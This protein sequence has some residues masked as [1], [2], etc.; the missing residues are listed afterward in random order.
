M[1]D[2][3]AASI[4]FTV[5]TCT[6]RNRDKQVDGGVGGGGGGTASDTA[7]CTNSALQDQGT[8]SHSES[9]HSNVPNPQP[10]SV[11]V[12]LER[13]VRLTLQKRGAEGWPCAV[14]QSLR[15]GE[16]VRLSPGEGPQSA[17]RLALK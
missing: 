3:H 14:I 8:S 17:W 12:R 11:L 7:P 9:F 13:V 15:L 16:G 10:L 6:L 1:G 5:S 2:L 4:L